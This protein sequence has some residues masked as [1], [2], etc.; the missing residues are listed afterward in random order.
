MPSIEHA[1]SQRTSHTQRE[2]ERERERKGKGEDIIETGEVGKPSSNSE[3][4]EIL[5]VP[6]HGMTLGKHCG[7]REQ[8]TRGELPEN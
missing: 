2:R 7:T 8:R 3:A 4:G 5:G 1:A 6:R